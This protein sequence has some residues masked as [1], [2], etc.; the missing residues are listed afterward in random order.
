MNNNTKELSAI[1]KEWANKSNK[2]RQ[3]KQYL[4]MFN[5]CSEADKAAIAMLEKL[6]ISSGGNLPKLYQTYMAIKQSS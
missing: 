4:T 6:D 3:Q 2:A 5:S 1:H